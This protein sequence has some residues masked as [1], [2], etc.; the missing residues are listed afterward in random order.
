MKTRLLATAGLVLTLAAGAWAAPITLQAQSLHTHPGLIVVDPNNETVVQLSCDVQW[1]AYKA[2]WLQVAVSPHDKRVLLFDATATSGQASVAV[3][4]AGDSTPLQLDVRVSANTLGNHVYFI[5]CGAASDTLPAVVSTPMPSPPSPSGPA[6][7]TAQA[8][9]GPAV[10][11]GKAWDEFVA[12][13]TPAQW[14]LLQTLIVQQTAAAYAAF[15][16]SL[17][18]GQAAV[19]A[20]LGPGAHLVPP[21]GATEAA[22]AA[23][24]SPN[25]AAAAANGLPSWAPW[26][27]QA[28]TTG[29]GLLV[30]YSLTNT[31]SAPLV[32]D[33]ARLQVVDANGAPIDGVSLT[34]QDTSGFEGRLT[35]GDAESGVIRISVTPSSG[36]Q[37][38]WTVVQLGSG[39]T[40]VVIQDVP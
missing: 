21:S 14:S 30:S 27:A 40:Y 19:W 28:T 6:T 9:S 18:P 11:P 31:G 13:L 22:G 10:T 17:S 23:P 12:H 4:V 38:R 35:P 34:R 36:A 5:A 16:A 29:A 2:P 26:Q 20:D 33:I 37:I 3:W 32:L 8:A 7:P 24:Q 25:T 15:T 39:Q 1:S